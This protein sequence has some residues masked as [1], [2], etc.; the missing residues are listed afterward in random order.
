MVER[1]MRRAA[2]GLGPRE[3]LRPRNQLVASTATIEKRAPRTLSSSLR[4]DNSRI[5]RRI[6]SPSQ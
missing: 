6:G 1:W 2:A 5:R 4:D 3:K